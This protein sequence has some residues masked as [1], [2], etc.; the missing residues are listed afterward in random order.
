MKQNKLWFRAKMY[1]WGWYPISW[2]GWIIT[3]LYV[4][5]VMQPAISIDKASHSGS[6]FLINFSIPFI[7]NTIF[8]LIICYAK[9]EK[10]KWRWG[11]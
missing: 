1:G 7:I 10:P 9:G 6:D 4:V 11:K 5:S 2:E 3:L 8:L